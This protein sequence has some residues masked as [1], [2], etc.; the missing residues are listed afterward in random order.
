MAGKVSRAAKKDVLAFL[1]NTPLGTLIT[2]GSAGVP[3]PSAVYF[4]VEKDFTL[5]FVTKAKTRKFRNLERRPGV[6]LYAFSEESFTTVSVRGRAHIVDDTLVFAQIIEQFQIIAGA[7]KSK[8]WLPPVAQI[9]AGHYVAVAL[10]P[11]MIRFRRYA[12]SIS[13]SG[14]LHELEFD[15]R[16][17]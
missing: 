15:P 11:S 2:M 14:V 16:S 12:P 1:E 7:K 5:Y 10:K 6:T 3:E 8:Q 9:E 13:E 17:A 4:S